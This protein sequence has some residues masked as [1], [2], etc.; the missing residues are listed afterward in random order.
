MEHLPNG[1]QLLGDQ[2]IRSNPVQID[3]FDRFDVKLKVPF[4][5]NQHD[6]KKHPK[7]LKSKRQMIETF[8]AQMCDQFNL[9]RNYANSYKGLVTRLTSK[10]SATSILHWLNYINGSKLAQIKHA[11]SF[12]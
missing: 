1:K 6:Y 7:R 8:F 10:L 5:I 9:R 11:Q 4:K 12:Q 3:L 2:T